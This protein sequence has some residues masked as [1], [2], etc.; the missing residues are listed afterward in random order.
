MINLEKEISELSKIRHELDRPRVLEMGQIKGK[1]DL[2]LES[3]EEKQFELEQLRNS[4]IKMETSKN[5]LVQ[6]FR[7]AQD[8]IEK[9]GLH[10]TNDAL[11]VVVE[12]N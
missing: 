7:W 8:Q 2:L 6:S 4:V 9:T 10:K 3:L 11:R 12:A 5:M 1:I